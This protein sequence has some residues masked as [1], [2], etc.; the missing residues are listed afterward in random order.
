MWKFIKRNWRWLLGI[1]GI[2]AGAVI[3]SMPVKKPTHIPIPDVKKQKAEAQGQTDTDKKQIQADA[4]A[5]KK[6]ISAMTPEQ[7]HNTLP[8]SVQKDIQDIKATTSA[9]VTD[10]IMKRVFEE[11]QNG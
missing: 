9:E 10:N 5:K 11:A 4:E 3:T 8:P 7:V 2:G 1:I 6:E